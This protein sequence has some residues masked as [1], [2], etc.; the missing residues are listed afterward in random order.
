[1][2]AAYLV[3]TVLASAVNGMASIANLTGHKH[4]IAQAEKMRIPRSW[5]LPLGLL[6]GAGALGLLAG[7]VVPVLGTLAAAGL[8]LY[9]IVA[10]GAHLRARDYDFG[11]W[12]V[13]FSLAVAALVVNLLHHGLAW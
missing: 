10:F 11:S 4:P 2:F 8:V 12:A 3:V 13:F 1:M 9:F 7:L 5:T 6:L